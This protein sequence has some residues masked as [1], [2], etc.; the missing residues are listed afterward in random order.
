MLTGLL[1]DRHGIRD[2][3]AARLPEE[4]VTVAERFRDAG[5]KTAAFVS[6]YPLAREFSC[7]Q[8]FDVYDDRLDANASGE[9]RARGSDD[10]GERTVADR[11]F[12]D[13]RLAGATTDAA[14]PWL[15][16][17]CRGGEPFFLWVH[18]FDP[19]ASYRPPEPFAARFGASSYEGEIAYAD[20]EIGRLLAEL[21]GERDRVAVVVAADH[22]ESLGEHHE[23]SHALFVYESTLRVPLLLTGPGVPRGARVEEPVSLAAVAPTLLE[24]AGLEP[25]EGVDGASLLP[26]ARGA[27]APSDPVFSESLYARLHFDWA[28]LRA[29]RSGSWKLIESPVPELFDLAADPH[30]TVNRAAAEP[31]RVA[32]LR[33]VLRRHEARGGALAAPAAGDAETRERLA[34]LGYIGGGSAPA[35]GKG[36]DLWNADGRDPKEMVPIFNRLQEVAALL[37]DRRDSGV[38]RILGEVLALDPANL[39]ATRQLALLR[40]LQENWA[41]AK[42]LCEDVLRRDPEDVQTRMNLASASL[43]LGDRAGARRAYETIVQ[44][45]PRHADALVL[46]GRLLGEDGRHADAIAALERAAKAAP[47]DAEVLASLGQAHEAAGDGA[48]ALLEYDRA[49]ALDAGERTAR[50]QKGLVLARANRIDEAI[51]VLREGISRNPEDPDLLNN[52]AWILA[53]RSVD[54]EEAFALAQRA[55]AAA[56]ED[57]AILDTWGWAAV[58]AGKPAEAIAPL[59]AALAATQDAAVRAHLGVALAETGSAEEGAALLEEAVAA[60]PDLAEIPEVK[61]WRTA[62]KGAG[63]SRRALSPRT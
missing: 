16:A 5:W 56:P 60:R 50:L 25:L 3:G 34:A 17:V 33:E 28:G 32:P 9:S 14:V 54:P 23:I 41:E 44:L 58:R 30:E 1:P 47:E 18:Y 13:E 21:G 63:V 27:A 53:D 59:R 39:E 46:L 40:R 8:G 48:R 12:Y 36:R 61:K 49:L 10:G 31:E 2:N 19:V 62:A 24:L 43:R 55:R 37:L 51:A 38:E 4:A 42:R 7:D 35:P 57:P 6:A 22:G 20:A 52:L 26:F 29:V 11:L 45:D 15:R